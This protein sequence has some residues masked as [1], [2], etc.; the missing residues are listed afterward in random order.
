MFEKI[1]PNPEGRWLSRTAHSLWVQ[2]FHES[3]PKKSPPEPLRAIVVIDGK[4]GPRIFRDEDTHLVFCEEKPEYSFILQVKLDENGDVAVDGDG[5]PL[6]PEYIFDNSEL[7]AKMAEL[8]FEPEYE[9]AEAAAHFY[10]L[11][12][13]ADDAESNVRYI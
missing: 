7:M 6:D 10:N 2:G 5:E 4:A 12:H 11:S 8:G 1:K 3:E 13:P 9:T